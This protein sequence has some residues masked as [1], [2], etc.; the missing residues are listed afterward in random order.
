MIRACRV[1]DV[2]AIRKMI[3]DLAE[4]E[5]VA[6]AVH[7]TEEDLHTALFG[8]QPIAFAHLV[9]DDGTGELLGFAL[10]YLSFS[11]WQ[12][13]GI[14]LEDLYVRPQARGSGLGKALLRE[15]ARICADRG[16]RRLEWWVLNWNEPAINFYKSLGAVPLD[17]LSV[18]RLT[19]D[20]L[21]DLAA[22][23]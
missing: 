16:Y 9:E 4:Y 21:T 3:R 18:F 2:P 6:H 23:G 22:S 7:I 12:G 17:E 20:P 11:T 1:D 10:W 19:G 5:R 8:A 14:H 13:T 15:L